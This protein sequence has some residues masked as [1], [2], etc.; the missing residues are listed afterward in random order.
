MENILINKD[1]TSCGACI[2]SCPTKCIS[3]KRNQLNNKIAIKNIDRCVQCGI[4][5]R[6]CHLSTK[7]KNHPIACY[8]AWSLDEK[9]RQNS[10]SGG[11]ASSLYKYFTKNGWNVFGVSNKTGFNRLDTT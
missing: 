11:V 8:A 6:V 2:V 3:F 4:C 9:I 1:C 7:Q 10:A 5:E